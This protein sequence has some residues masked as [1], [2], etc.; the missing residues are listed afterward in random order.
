MYKVEYFKMVDG[1]E[2]RGIVESNLNY[3]E[4]NKLKKRLDSDWDLSIIQ[5]LSFCIVE[6]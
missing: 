2:Q 3:K 5:S 6:E 1:L 4:A